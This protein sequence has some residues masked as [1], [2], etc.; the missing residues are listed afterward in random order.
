MIH[1]VFSP[2]DCTTNHSCLWWKR[3]QGY[4]YDNLEQSVRLT[5]HHL[6]I[7]APNYKTQQSRCC[8]VLAMLLDLLHFCYFEKVKNENKNRIIFEI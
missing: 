4:L 5:V 3:F 1:T 8:W 7:E 2:S 6:L